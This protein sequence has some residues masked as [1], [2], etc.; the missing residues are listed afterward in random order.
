MFIDLDQFKY[1]NDTMGHQAGDE[2]LCMVA[3]RL[4]GSLRKVDI[5]GRLGGDEFGIIIPNTSREEVGLG[6]PATQ[7]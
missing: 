7:L 3:R 1:I 6:T 5:L 4:A 2:Y